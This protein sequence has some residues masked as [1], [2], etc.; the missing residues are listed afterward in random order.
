[1]RSTSPVAEPPSFVDCSDS[2]SN[3][4]GEVG[5][6]DF[7]ESSV[8]ASWW[9]FTMMTLTRGLVNAKVGTEK[10]KERRT[11]ELSRR[12]KTSVPLSSF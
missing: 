10:R 7:L 4:Y 12:L 2:F 6:L 1:M 8:V 9:K 11:E 3:V 5:T